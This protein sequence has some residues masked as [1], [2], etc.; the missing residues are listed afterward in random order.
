[1]LSVALWIFTVNVVYASWVIS[2]VSLPLGG[3]SKAVGQYNETIYL[4]AS[5]SPTY[6]F[7]EFAKYNIAQNNF[8]NEDNFQFNINI[9]SNSHHYTQINNTIYM[10][11]SD[12]YLS[13]Y[14]MKTNTYIPNWQLDMFISRKAC[15]T[16]SNNQLFIIQ[17]S[18]SGYYLI[19][20]NLL[21]MNWIHDNP[22]PQEQRLDCGCLV[23]RNRQKLYVIGGYSETRGMITETNEILEIDGDIAQ[24]QWQYI[25]NLT[26]PLRGIRPVLFK[27]IIFAIGGYDQIYENDT[28]V[29]NYAVDY[30]H[31]INPTTGNVFLSSEKLSYP[32]IDTSPIVVNDIIYA[33]SGQKYIGPKS[34][35]ITT[36]WMYYYEPTTTPT[37]ISISPSQNPTEYPS[38]Y[39][40]NSPTNTTIYP[41]LQPTE[42]PSYLTINPTMI[43]TF[44]P[45]FHPT[46]NPTF[47]PSLYPTSH[48][49]FIPTND[50]TINPSIGPTTNPSNDPVIN[51]SI[52]PTIN[53]SNV[54]TINPSIGPTI[55]PS[56]DPTITPSFNPTVFPTMN[57]VVSPT[58]TAE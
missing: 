15:I 54:P 11:S 44:N 5:G 25:D 30:V 46:T 57:P 9:I 56:I 22:S 16:S 12:D 2:D 14:N 45:T 48:P 1:M 27:N 49:T 19:R 53:P 52:D 33:F 24:N 18:G 43:P 47:N 17:L 39:P 23:D 3:W 28:F 21:S 4:I 50:P 40:T 38:I 7:G 35:Q 58:E 8:T 6:Q 32:I 20:M 13:I 29:G 37:Y 51:P 10:I 36:D 34:W 41:T 31:I 42:T 26:I 55:N